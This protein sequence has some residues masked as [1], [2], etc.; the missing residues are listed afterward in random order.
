MTR[1]SYYWDNTC[2][3]GESKFGWLCV[4]L[5][6]HLD[7]VVPVGAEVSWELSCI[8]PGTASRNNIQKRSASKG[9][10]PVVSVISLRAAR[11]EEPRLKVK[12]SSRPP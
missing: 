6:R 10:V 4:E 5:Q 2:V 11:F 3:L 1:V 8:N 7:P 9:L 12:L